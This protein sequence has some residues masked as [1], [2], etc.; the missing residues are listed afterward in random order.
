MTTEEEI[1]KQFTFSDCMQVLA[2]FIIR[3]ALA[4]TF[5]LNCGIFKT[6]NEP[7]TNF[8]QDNFESLAN[9]LAS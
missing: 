3:L 2:P 5:R 7:S 6:L 9:Q 4:E 8:D 1:A